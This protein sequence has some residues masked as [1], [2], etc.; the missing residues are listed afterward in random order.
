M[1]TDPEDESASTA[2][3]LPS[4]GQVFSGDCTTLMEKKKK[5]QHRNK[6]YRENT[7]RAVSVIRK[8]LHHSLQCCR[9]CYRDRTKA[10]E[11]NVGSRSSY[12]GREPFFNKTEPCHHYQETRLRGK[13]ESRRTAQKGHGGSG[14]GRGEKGRRALI[15]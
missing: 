15:R 2:L 10:S 8:L 3:A 7:S 6:Q 14:G 5:N 4:K 9:R 11:P 1:V 12:R 13:K